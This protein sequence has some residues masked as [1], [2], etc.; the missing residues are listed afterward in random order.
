MAALV[1]SIRLLRPTCL[2]WG[3][4][5]SRWDI[6]SEEWRNVWAKPHGA[7]AAEESVS[8]S[9][10]PSLSLC[11]LQ[12][13]P[14][15]LF[16]ISPILLIPTR[17]LRSLIAYRIKVITGGYRLAVRVR[18]RPNGQLSS[19]SR[20]RTPAMQSIQRRLPMPCTPRSAQPH[21][22]YLTSQLAQNGLCGTACLA[23]PGFD[24]ITGL[25][26]PKASAVISTLGSGS[27]M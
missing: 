25:G 27:S 19:L 11:F 26:T 3:E 12:S 21:C 13:F 16:L 10:P 9:L 1:S 6:Q 7:P 24:L 23:S 22:P 20:V 8:L 4:Q 18:A 14:A 5:R 2:R 17:D 15:G